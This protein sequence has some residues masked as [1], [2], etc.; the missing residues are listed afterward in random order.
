MFKLEKKQIYASWLIFLII[1]I[2]SFST[3]VSP[4]LNQVVSVSLITAII[5]LAVYSLE[6][7]VLLVLAELFIGSMGHLFR[8]DICSIQIPIRMALW[9]AVIGVFFIRLLIQL[10]KQK[11]Q[12]PYWLS[13]KN[14][15][16]RKFFGILGV[17]IVIACLNGY[18]R[19]HDPS[20]I[21]ADFNAWLYLL[22]LWPLIVVY[23]DA[24]RR[25]I[26]RLVNIFL[27]AAA[28][29]SLKTLF[30]L[31][32]F[33][34]TTA[35][36]PNIYTW[37]RQTLVGEMTPTKTGWPRVFI[38]GQVYSA[39][40][41]F[42][43]FWF[44][45]A[46][47]RWPSFRWRVNLLALLSA[48]F[49]LSAIFI[50]FSRS[51]WVALAVALVFSLLL[52]WRVASFKKMLVSGL[53][54]L[55]AGALGFAMIYLVVAFP[56]VRSSAGNLGANFL[57]R[58]SNGNEPALAS[59]WSLLPILLAEIRQEPFL[60]QGYG[61]TVTYFSRDPRIL[62][63]NPSGEYTTYAF[64]WGYLDL[65]LKLGLLGLAAYLL[66]LYKLLADGLRRAGQDDRTLFMTLAVG[67]V[68]L[69][70]THFF[71]PYLNHPLGLGFLLV[72][73]CLIWP[74]RVY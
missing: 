6:Y 69:I 16:G 19:G 23:G 28:W 33:T 10:I 35:F 55:L 49:F 20:L 40:A 18:W 41:F 73:S 72:S 13:L 22:F 9:A 70:A 27:A 45:Q 34:H 25:K 3:F 1:E 63:K 54:C 24:D 42:A 15:P 32:I 68:F 12:A 38:Q 64:E 58:V 21:F 48:G 74:N 46:H 44:N 61:A 66:L 43:V 71:T 37:L 52:V 5:L 51:F 31:F 47:L 53:W 60:G 57:D 26:N 39:I 4:T 67:L 50:S 62:E 14:F 17:F 59:R 2:L 29:L 7:G 8:L 56:Y 65:W 30:L 11:K 36:A